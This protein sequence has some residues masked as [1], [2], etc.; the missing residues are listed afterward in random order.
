MQNELKRSY[1]SRVSLA[2]AG[3]RGVDAGDIERGNEIVGF[4]LA[5]RLAQKFSEVFENRLLWS[6]QYRWDR[7][8]RH[9]PTTSTGNH[10]TALHLSNLCNFLRSTSKPAASFPGS[11]PHAR[12]LPKLLSYFFEALHHHKTRCFSS[13]HFLPLVYRADFHTRLPPTRRYSLE[14]AVARHNLKPNFSHTRQ[15]QHLTPT[16]NQNEPQNKPYLRQEFPSTRSSLG[17]FE[18]AFKMIV[19]VCSARRS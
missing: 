11:I 7:S 18:E 10:P 3:A 9:K 16:P 8:T 6:G 12:L 4:F 1:S 2:V 14:K 17:T 19:E 5:Q 13:S 15:F